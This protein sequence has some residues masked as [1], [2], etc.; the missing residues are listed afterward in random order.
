MDIVTYALCKKYVKDSLAGAGALKGDKGDSGKSAYELAVAAGFSGSQKEWLA[1]L[2]GSAPYVGDNGNWFVDGTD[3]NVPARTITSYDELENLP[4]IPTKIS[5]LINDAEFIT[6]ASI[7][8]NLSEL[9]NDSRFMTLDDLPTTVSSFE[10]DAGYLTSKDVSDFAKSSEVPTKV[11]QLENDAKYLTTHQ[12]IKTING[13][14][15]IGTGNIEIKAG[16]GDDLISAVMG[17]DFVTN[18]T[19]GYLKAGTTISK[20]DT[21]ADILYKILYKP[22]KTTIDFVFGGSLSVPYNLDYLSWKDTLLDQNVDTI[23]SKG[24]TRTIKTGQEGGAELGQY[25]VMACT[26]GVRLVQL[27]KMVVQGMEFI[28]LDFEMIE[29][30]EY[31]IYYYPTKT[32]D[33]D[34]TTYIFEFEEV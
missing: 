4:D 29:T 30:D 28:P 23:L 33:T 22:L 14:S 11:S 1:S 13:E 6:S 17:R 20:D 9:N 32:Y 21:L 12:K 10:N 7:P 34:G 25:P 19:L 5:E 8:T 26:K 2:K 15:I 24:L 27:K 16:S 31:Y 18:T 3:T